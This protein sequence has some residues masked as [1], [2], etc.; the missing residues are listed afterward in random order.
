MIRIGVGVISRRR[1][2]SIEG[3]L[4]PAGAALFDVLLPVAPTRLQ[5]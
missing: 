1:L 4:S 2:P 3:T 5:T